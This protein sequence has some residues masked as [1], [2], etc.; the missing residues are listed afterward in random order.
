EVVAAAVGVDACRG[1]APQGVGDDHA[2]GAAGMNASAVV[3]TRIIGNHVVTATRDVNAR[4]VVVASI[5]G[6]VRPGSRDQDA[7]PVVVTIVV[8]YGRLR[9]ILNVDTHRTRGYIRAGYRRLVIKSGVALTVHVY[10]LRSAVLEYDISN[11]Y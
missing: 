1:I 9:G 2:A 7:R 8:E 4:C 10:G 6:N 3:V 5:V 11:V